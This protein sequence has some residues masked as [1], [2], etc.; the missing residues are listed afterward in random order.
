MSVSAQCPSP[1]SMPWFPPAR[2]AG[3]TARR[4]FG[5][6]LPHVG[7]Q[8]VS[9]SARGTLQGTGPSTQAF[10]PLHHG[11]RGCLPTQHVLPTGRGR[12]GCQEHSPRPSQL[13]C[14][15]GSSR[16][17]CAPSP[18]PEGRGVAVAGAGRAGERKRLLL[19]WHSSSWRGSSGD[20]WETLQPPVR[21]RAA[22][23]RSG[24]KGGGRST[25][26]CRLPGPWP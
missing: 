5:E 25:G 14:M 10:P 16:P 8:R 1:F 6:L 15:R 2:E 20:P 13:L 24:M 17:V 18:P 9:C 4:V 3:P 26:V 21:T 23:W 19:C 7:T 22:W 12:D 11:L